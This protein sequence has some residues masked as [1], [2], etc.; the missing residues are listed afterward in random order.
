M[1]SH[2]QGLIVLFYHEVRELE[3]TRES[4]IINQ[5]YGFGND[6]ALQTY[7]IRER[8][9]AY[10]RNCTGDAN[11]RHAGTTLKS[12]IS[13][14]SDRT[15]DVDTPQACASLE[16]R[17]A[18]DLD[19]IGNGETCQTSATRKCAPSYLREGIGFSGFS[20]RNDQFLPCGVRGYAGVL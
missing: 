1:I 12:L 11:A 13:N 19:G 6:G 10:L 20:V 7:A 2:V 17:I 4:V 5:G 18:Y 15:W 8:R 14:K 3:A 9:A 16:S